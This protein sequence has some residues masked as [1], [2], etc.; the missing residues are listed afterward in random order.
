M[1]EA[2][3]ITEDID[4]LS[5]KIKS[6]TDSCVRASNDNDPETLSVG[7]MELAR[8]NSALGR[9]AKYAMY[10]A[11]T[12]EQAYKAA[13]EQYK[14][15]TINEGK[16][17]TFADTSRYIKSTP[18]HKIWNDALLIAE[19]AE[20]L[21]WRTGDFLKYGQSRLSLIKMDIVNG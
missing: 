5:G 20:D 10:V 2:D 14:V 3:Q 11:R 6:W 12:A 1:A 9:K 19:Q 4:F 17:A 16:S 21:A 8:I 18:D 7:L 13:R 15:D